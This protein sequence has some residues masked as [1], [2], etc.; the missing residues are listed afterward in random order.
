MSF[1]GD[2]LALVALMLHVASTTGQALAVALLLLPA[3]SPRRFSARSPGRWPT[4]S[5]GGG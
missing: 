5:S 4:G 3:T 1:L 2:S